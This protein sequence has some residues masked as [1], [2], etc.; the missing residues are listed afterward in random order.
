MPPMICL[1]ALRD[2]PGRGIRASACRRT[3]R[4]LYGHQ[5]RPRWCTALPLCS[6]RQK[7]SDPVSARGRRYHWGRPS[8][9]P[10][11]TGSRTPTTYR[12]PKIDFVKPRS[13]LASSI[14]MPNTCRRRC[15]GG[16]LEASVRAPQDWRQ[17]CDSGRRTPAPIVSWRLTAVFCM[18]F[19]RGFNDQILEALGS[20]DPGRSLRSGLRRGK[21]GTGCRLGRTSAGS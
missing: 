14:W 15:G 1:G 8:N 18:R 13:R 20:D 9:T 3:G 11:S 21:L 7:N 17:E 5:R 2:E 16:V 10:L 4:R 19:V 6:G 12:F